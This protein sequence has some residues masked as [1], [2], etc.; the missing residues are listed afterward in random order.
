MESRIGEKCDRD[1]RAD[2]SHVTLKND[3]ASDAAEFVGDQVAKKRSG[4][5]AGE[6]DRL[7]VRLDV[8]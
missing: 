3:S 2:Q 7:G 6:G 4:S 1:L 8:R 5:L